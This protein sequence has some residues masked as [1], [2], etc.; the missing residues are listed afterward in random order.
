MTP[1]DDW[2]NVCKTEDA[3]LATAQIRDCCFRGRVVLG[4]FSAMDHDVDGVPFSSGLYRTALCNAVVLD[5]ALVR[6]T[7]AIRDALVGPR[8]TIV[9]CGSVLG[10]AST[11]KTTSFANGQTLHVGVETGG[12]DLRAIAD[13]PFART[14]PL[15]STVSASLTLLLLQWRRGSRRSEGTLSC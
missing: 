15:H 5:D 6:N 8:A 1:A 11:V 9:Q 13:L 10:P 2:S 7:L 3:P 14:Y 12:R 4:R